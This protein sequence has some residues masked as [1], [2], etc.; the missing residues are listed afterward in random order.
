MRYDQRP[1]QVDA[2]RFM[3]NDPAADLVA[4]NAWMTDLQVDV[5]PTYAAILRTYLPEDDEIFPDWKPE[6]ILAQ[7]E[8]SSGPTP[9]VRPVRAGD[10]ILFPPNPASAQAW[11]LDDATFHETYVLP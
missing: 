2:M 11:V 5:D 6:W 9:L 7:A 4:L 10:W 8:S 1:P 3:P